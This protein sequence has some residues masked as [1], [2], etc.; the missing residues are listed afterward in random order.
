VFHAKNNFLRFTVF[1]LKYKQYMREKRDT[2]DGFTSLIDK[3]L[4]SLKPMTK[5]QQFNAISSIPHLEIG[6][7]KKSSILVKLL[8]CIHLGDQKN[9]IVDIGDAS[10]ATSNTHPRR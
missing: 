4:N 9:N 7:D 5:S 3:V 2:H 10:G 8:N 6:D 1:Q